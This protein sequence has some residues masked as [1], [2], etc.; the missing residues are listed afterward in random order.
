[1]Y[2]FFSAAKLALNLTTPVES[3]VAPLHYK[4]SLS[5]VSAAATHQVAAIDADAGV[6]ASSAMR[7]RDAK[8][9]ILF[10]EAG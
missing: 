5:S 3:A 2:H 1:M 7:A 6:V 8:S 4:Y 9:R 10:A